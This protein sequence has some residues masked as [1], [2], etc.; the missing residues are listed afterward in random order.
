[1][2]SID[3]LNP[4]TGEHLDSIVDVG[5]DGVDDA[6]RRA[7]AAFPRWAATPA[8]ERSAILQRAG[9]L[10][11]EHRVELAE[12]LTRENGKPYPQAFGEIGD[13]A[14]LLEKYGHEALRLYGETIPG[15]A[16][17]GTE[18]DLILTRREPRGVLGAVIP[19]NSPMDIFAHKVGPALAS[20][21]CAVIKPPEVDPL[22]VMR[23]TELLHEAGVPR[24]VLILVN[25]L[26]M[27]TGAP[28]AA[29]RGIDVVSFTG[30]TAAGLSVAA[31]AI[32]RLRPVML[33]LGGNDPLIVCHD[34]DL[35]L[36]LD[37]VMFGR[38]LANGQ[39]C[40][41]NKRLLVHRDLVEDFTAGL[42]ERVTALRMGDPSADRTVELGPLITDVAAK[43]VAA[44]V[45]TAM[46]EG[47]ELLAGEPT[48]SGNF[49]GPIVL[50][51]VLPGSSIASDAEV[52]G[53]VFPV[54]SFDNDQQAIR[55]ANDSS[56]G[57]N[58][59]IFTRD[60]QRAVYLA[61]HVQAG[62]VSVNAS[63]LYRPDAIEYGGYKMSGFGREG[64]RASFHE[65]TQ[66]K[67]IALRGVLPR[68]TSG[69]P[70]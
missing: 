43:R 23:A 44:Q 6:V 59:S 19:F 29:H 51:R 40:C 49:I 50:G 34:A 27:T 55:I 2:T 5:A 3:V 48:A 4:A 45:Q 36:T 28:L 12:L 53:P 33:E 14:R 35:E 7:R 39:I 21:N 41:A 10:L 17:P 67:T 65:L 47:A 52:F 30:S 31:A 46:D 66:V 24:D 1:M 15:D 20:G 8:H 16:Q 42:L 56:F 11:Q 22:T 26:G 57:L 18:G 70:L 32:A 61:H 25:G 38:T 62:T 9:G 58:A 68:E 37:Q 60:L 64:L 69:Y 54:V 63:G 13:A